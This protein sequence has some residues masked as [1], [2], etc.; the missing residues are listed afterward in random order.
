MSRRDGA[1]SIDS[2]RSNRSNSDSKKLCKECTEE[3]QCL[4]N[5]A[6]K[7][8]TSEERRWLY[9]K[10]WESWPETLVIT[11]TDTN[12]S[13]QVSGTYKRSKCRQTINQAALWIREEA[14]ALYLLLKPE[15]S[16]TGPD[17]PIIS[18]SLCHKDLTSIVATLPALW[19]PC[20]PLACD[21]QLVKAVRFHAWSELPEMECLVPSTTIKISKPSPVEESD[22]LLRIVDLN[23]SDVEM[24]ASRSIA[25]DDGIAILSMASG[26]KAQQT[27]RVFNSVCVPTILQY[28]AACGINFDLRPNAEWIQLNSANSEV[29]FGTCK[30]TFPS[31]P[32]EHWKY[33]KDRQEWERMY[34]HRESRA[35]Y[36]ALENRPRAFEF[37]LAMK[38]NTLTIKFHPEVVAHYAAGYL[39]QGRGPDVTKGIQ[40]SFKMFSSQFQA[41]P[42]LDAFRVSSC[43]AEDPTDVML[44]PPFKLYDRQQK[45]VTKM[46]AVENRKTTFEEIEMYE[47]YMPGSTGWSVIAKAQRQTSIAG[48]VIADAIG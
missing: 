45:V 32:E 38:E 30:K 17:I 21:T 34:E 7:S 10:N 28:T 19:Q 25:S 47:E 41:D 3:N 14:P 18:R 26:Q 46:L 2:Q 37:V 43:S 36:K 11:A 20:D 42:V 6:Q 40:V 35:F 15:V 44:K 13:A 27:V 24:L 22:V 33:N 4:W 5:F 12:Q 8:H 48:G 9:A 39:S 1:I 29:P 16:R 31:R 23:E